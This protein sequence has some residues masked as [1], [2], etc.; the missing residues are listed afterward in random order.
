MKKTNLLFLILVLISGCRNVD[1][2]K[3]VIPLPDHR[4]LAW[5]QMEFYAFIH[6]NMNTFTNMEWGYGDESPELFNPAELDCRQWV[7]VC[8][9]AGMKGIILTAKHHDG[10]CLWPSQFTEHSVK[11]SPWKAGKGD[12]VKELSEACKEYGLKMGL[13]LS[14]WDRNHS[15]YG[16]PEYITYYRNQ[17]RELLTNYGEIFE[18][19][20]DG[21]NGGTGYYGG[22]DEDRKVNRKTYY[23]WPNTFKIVRELQPDAVIFSDAGPDIRWVGNEQGWANETNWCLLR[24]DE[25]WPGWPRYKEL[26]SGHEDGTHWVPAEVDVSIRPGWYYHSAEDSQVKSL[27][28]LLD[29]YY[30]SVG[31]NANLLLN[32]PVDNRGLIH[33]KDV[34]QVYKLAEALK[35]DFDI[36]LAGGKKV[37]ATNTRGNSRLYRGSNV[38][39]GNGETYWTTENNITDASIVI[40]LEEPVEFNR[41][42]I[43][44]Y[45]PL[46]QRVQEF[47]LEAMVED[48][49][50]L[51]ASET[52][53]GY[54]RIL[55][56]PTI[57]TSRVRLNIIRSKASPLI[58]N[59]ELYNAPK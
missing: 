37:I 45:I 12:V 58:S 26:R 7:R 13:Y 56:L 59:I 1:P 2:P 24:R 50:K 52:T 10:F 9:E 48:N 31:R 53:I 28:Q 16:N 42:V 25:A 8:K 49:W 32:F 41:F 19:W 44:E 11:N 5:H 47:T 51:L 17:L 38:N 46:G 55:R 14:P 15:D 57:K 54:K 36:E 29:I 6:F 21:A 40:D 23:D 39:D 22:A 30:H 4:H 20:I 43:Q 3:S 34:E 35:A 33:E 27:K 18:F